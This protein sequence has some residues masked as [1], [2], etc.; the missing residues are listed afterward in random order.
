MTSYVASYGGQMTSFASTMKR[1]LTLN[2][3]MNIAQ[4]VVVYE[5]PGFNVVNTMM[6]ANTM[7]N[8]L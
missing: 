6:D 1:Q 5:F 8:W 3:S 7:A 4:K 2:S